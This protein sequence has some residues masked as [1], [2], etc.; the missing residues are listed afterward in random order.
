MTDFQTLKKYEKDA[1]I[2]L[3]RWRCDNCNHKLSLSEIMLGICW[4]CGHEI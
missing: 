2:S 1:S 3:I 4:Y